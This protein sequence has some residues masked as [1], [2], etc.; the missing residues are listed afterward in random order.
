MPFSN[1]WRRWVRALRRCDCNSRP[2]SARR[3]WFDCR[4]GS[5]FRHAR[6]GGGSA[7]PGVL[8]ARR[9]GARSTACCMRAGWNAFSGFAGVVRLHYGH[10]SSVARA[11][12]AAPAG[13]GSRVWPQPAGTLHRRP[14]PGCQPALVGAV[15]GTRRAGWIEQGWCRTCSCTP[16]NHRAAEQA[17]RFHALGCANALP[18]LPSCM[19]RR[20]LQSSRACSDHCRSRRF[21]RRNAALSM[22]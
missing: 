8:R 19:H 10:A 4:I 22:K 1:C 21:R 5:S 15:G 9:R 2:A 3:S 6:T 11:A 17:L 18:G 14:G 7:P 12:E 20:H 16:D 13:T